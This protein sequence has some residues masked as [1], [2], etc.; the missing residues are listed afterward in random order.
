VTE[1]SLVE[2]LLGLA[3]LGTIALI[4]CTTWRDL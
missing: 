4:L 3:V 2:L 1:E